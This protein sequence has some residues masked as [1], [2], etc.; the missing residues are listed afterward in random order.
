MSEKYDLNKIL[1][2]IKEDEKYGQTSKGM[3]ASQNDIK[4]ILKKKEEG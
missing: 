2:E 3:K 1:E 4:K